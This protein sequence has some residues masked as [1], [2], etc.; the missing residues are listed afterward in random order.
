MVQEIN[1]ISEKMIM[2]NSREYKLAIL[3]VPMLIHRL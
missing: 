3:V 1:Q 2:H